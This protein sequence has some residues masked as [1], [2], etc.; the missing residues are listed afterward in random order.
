MT[1]ALAACHLPPEVKETLVGQV[2]KCCKTVLTSAVE[3]PDDGI[4]GQPLAASDVSPEAAGATL[5]A[6]SAELKRQD[7]SQRLLT[8]ACSKELEEEELRKVAVKMEDGSFMYRNSKGKL[9]TLEERQKRVEHNS[10]VSFT[11]SFDGTLAA[12]FKTSMQDVKFSIYA[13]LS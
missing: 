4:D 8:R 6:V 7:T 5:D 3:I 1:Q 10:Y 13:S 11:R 12:Y 2:Q 9:E